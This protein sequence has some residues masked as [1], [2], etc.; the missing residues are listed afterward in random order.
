MP[1]QVIVHERRRG[2]KWYESKVI[3][4]NVISVL[5]AILMLVSQSPSLAPYGE[6][7]ALGQGI[8]NILLRFTTTQP[9]K[10]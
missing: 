8:L 7:L 3:W 9:V 4:A 2:K 5:V 6:W 10:S 1:D